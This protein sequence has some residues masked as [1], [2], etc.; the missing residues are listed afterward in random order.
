[1][2]LN[3]HG[4]RGGPGGCHWALPLLLAAVAALPGCVH[5][6][7]RAPS[8]LPPERVAAALQQQADRFR[9]VSAD[10]S[11]KI[12]EIT[13]DGEHSIP[14]LGG[15]IAFDGAGSRLWLRT[16]KVTREVFTLKAVGDRFWLK[17]PSTCEIATGGPV[18]YG[19]LPHLIR[20]AEAGAIFAGPHALGISWAGTKMSVDADHYRFEATALGSPYCRVLVDRRKV[21][22]SAI[23]RYDAL[24]R[25]VTAIRLD[26]HRRIGGVMIPRVLVI[27]RPLAGVRVKLRLGDMKVNADIPDGL[28]RTQTPPG[29]EV[30]DLDLRP[31]SDV[32]ALSG[33]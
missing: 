18:A 15:H 23:E 4:R 12:T 20:P 14:A 30:I 3:L 17:F 24:G 7:A 32:R 8:P 5:L 26:D 28:F 22:V 16:T 33:K 9:S 27:E 19:R 2:S 11:L 13:P 6:C 21:A 29:W 10:I 25:V 31:I 1:M